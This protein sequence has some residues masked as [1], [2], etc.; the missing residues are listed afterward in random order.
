MG[1]GI[2]FKMKASRFMLDPISI[3]LGILAC[4]Y[5]LYLFTVPGSEAKGSFLISAVMIGLVFGLLVLKSS[6]DIDISPDEIAGS[7]LWTMIGIAG[8]FTF[9]FLVITSSQL[10]LLST[11][12][13]GKV[14]YAMMGIAEE[15]AFR[16]ALLQMIYQWLSKIGNA[17]FLSTLLTSTIFMLYHAEVYGTHPTALIAVFVSSIVLCIIFIKS[18]RLT[19]SL[20]AHSIVNFLVS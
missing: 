10:S 2:Y 12:F 8:I 3:F 6:I 18:K 17:L 13:S 16:F 7:F 15:Y 5:G 19:P 9:Q 11:A 14:F 4:L 20:L 1:R